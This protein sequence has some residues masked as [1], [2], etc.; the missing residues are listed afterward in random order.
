[1]SDPYTSTRVPGIV[2]P[3]ET[4][5]AR[6]AAVFAQLDLAVFV[7][8]SDGTL[9]MRN[10]AAE[11]YVD[12]RHSDAVAAAAIQ[13]LLNNA[14]RGTACEEELALI[15]PPPQVLHVR[16][17]PLFDNGALLGAA[18]FVR[19]LSEPRR[20]ERMRR[21]FV[22]NVS[23][24]LKTPIGAIG[25]LTETLAASD[26]PRVIQE[27]AARVVV[28]VDRLARIVD[29]LLALSELEA[30]DIGDHGMARL[31]EV[32]AEAAHL[33]GAAAR[34][35]NID[36]VVVDPI[37]PVIVQGA[38]RHVLSAIS[39]LLD[40]AI[41]YSEP[42]STVAIAVTAGAEDATIEVRDQG[43]GVPSRDL[44]RIFERFY[45]VDRAR[46]RATGGTGLGLSIVRNVAQANGGRVEV[47]STEGVGSTFRLILPITSEP[48]NGGYD[49]PTFNQGT[50]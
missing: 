7:V 39:N 46:S 21:D 33:L 50:P 4:A 25:V 32:V 31:D 37:P 30:N 27:F 5:L 24:E 48:T 49:S 15:G 8:D 13:Q 18:A 45:R 41:K 16:A 20:V 6:I 47:E 1:M 42:A 44:E 40:N 9:I 36:L 29:D 14:Y 11:R 26:D 22:A 23:H 38:S 34:S 2:A 19:D 17:V 35:S 3:S 10:P 28:E 43:I 12:A